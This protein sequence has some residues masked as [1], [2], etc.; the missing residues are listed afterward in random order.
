MPE[1]ASE[2]V[3]DAQLRFRIFTAQEGGIQSRGF[4]AEGWFFS[5]PLLAPDGTYWDCRVIYGHRNLV[6]G[7][8]YTLG[9]KYLSPDEAP[10]HIP[11]GADVALGPP[12]FVIGVGTVL[13]HP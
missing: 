13:S 7:I 8:D 10:R 12:S 3:P 2:I 6:A 5:C 1:Y 4:S 9:I 11:A